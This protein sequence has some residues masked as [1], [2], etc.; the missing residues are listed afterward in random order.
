MGIKIDLGDIVSSGSV[1]KAIIAVCGDECEYA[2]GDLNGPT[3]VTSGPGPGWTR[4]FD[5]TDFA[6]RALS[7]EY[8]AKGYIDANDGRM[9]T[10]DGDGE[11]V[12]SDDSVVSLADV[13]ASDLLASDLGILHVIRAAIDDDVV[14]QGDGWALL[15]DVIEARESGDHKAL[16]LVRF[17]KEGLVDA[18]DVRRLLL[19]AGEW[20]VDDEEKDAP[21]D[22]SDDGR[23]WVTA[24]RTLRCDSVAVASWT[25][26]AVG[27]YGGNGGPGTR[28]DA[29]EVDEDTEGG[30]LP[31]HIEAVLSVLGLKDEIPSVPEPPLASDVYDEDEEGAY[32]VYWATVGDDSHVV[33]RYDTRDAAIAVAD[34]FS[35]SLSA[36]HPGQLLCGYEVRELVDGEWVRLDQ[37]EEAGLHPG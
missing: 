2:S 6:E 9:A 10:L 13:E 32:G 30:R 37:T 36:N 12:W 7:D 15:D 31:D 26:C 18:S 24:S 4:H 1:G 21:E 33:K 19:A 16:V 23:L 5:A 22:L 17:I 34:Q 14:T 20:R 11:I 3:F 25:R 27:S 28:P 35:R 29:W 8:G